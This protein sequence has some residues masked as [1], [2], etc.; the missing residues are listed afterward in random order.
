M[1]LTNLYRDLLRPGEDKKHEFPCRQALVGPIHDDCVTPPLCLSRSASWTTQKA[2]LKSSFMSSLAPPTKELPKWPNPLPVR[3]LAPIP[4]LDSAFALHPPTPS[5]PLRDGEFQPGWMRST[6]I[7]PAVVPRTTA[8]IP[9][10]SMEPGPGGR[11]AAVEEA[12]KYIQNARVEHTLRPA[13]ESERSRKQLWISLDRYKNTTSRRSEE[14][15]REP[16]TLLFTHPCGLH[17][18]VS[19]IPALSFCF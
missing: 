5:L 8:D 9:C 12:T 19:D 4:R 10:P 13:Q 18:E 14:Q 3:G 7:I 2:P 16:L 6:H 11:A 15:E 1:R 17:K